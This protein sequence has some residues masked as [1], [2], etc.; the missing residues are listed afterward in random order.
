MMKKLL[1]LFFSSQ[2]IFSV[3]FNDLVNLELNQQMELI[4]FNQNIIEQKIQLLQTYQAEN[5][6]LNLSI[7]TLPREEQDKKKKEFKNLYILK[8]YRQNQIFEIK[9]QELLHKHELQKLQLQNIA[10]EV[11]ETVIARQ[12]QEKQSLL[13]IHES[14]KKVWYHFL[15]KL[16]CKFLNFC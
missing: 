16:D 3:Q 8:M 15:V 1:F 5:N 4:N 10:R 12:K 9:K 2:T 6:L 7:Q 13:K 14:E 11:I